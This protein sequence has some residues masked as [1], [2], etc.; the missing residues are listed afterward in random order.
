MSTGSGLVHLYLGPLPPEGAGGC[1]Q[2]RKTPTPEYHT[3]GASKN[4]GSTAS[5][6]KACVVASCNPWLATDAR[7]QGTNTAT[8]MPL[9]TTARR[10]LLCMT[11]PER[12][13][14][15]GKATRRLNTV[16]AMFR[17]ARIRIAATLTWFSGISNEKSS[18]GIDAANA[19]Q[20][21]HQPKRLL[22]RAR[23]L[24]P[25]PGHTQYRHRYRTSQKG[26]LTS[27][28]GLTTKENWNSELRADRREDHGLAIASR[29]RAISERSVQKSAPSRPFARRP[30]LRMASPEVESV[31]PTFDGTSG[32]NSGPR[33][34]P[35]GPKNSHSKNRC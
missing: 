9:T 28:I 33:G 30:P 17:T 23:K 22:L 16:A 4:N 7:N 15:Q 27:S 1:S 12:S 34:L 26:Q 3:T 31:I 13:L 6:S 32:N 8:R 10:A 29:P 35:S 18:S 21:R 24:A 20:P 5:A 19:R 25:R 14:G 11:F 2:K